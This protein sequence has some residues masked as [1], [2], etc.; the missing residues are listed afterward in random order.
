M[1]PFKTKHLNQTNNLEEHVSACSARLRLRLFE[2]KNYFFEKQKKLKS[3]QISKFD[4]SLA[5]NLE[6]FGISRLC[7]SHQKNKPLAA[8]KKPLAF[9]KK[10]LRFWAKLLF[11]SKN[12]FYETNF[13][14]RDKLSKE[15]LFLETNFFLR[16][17]FFLSQTSSFVR[18]FV[19]W[20]K[21]CFS[22]KMKFYGQCLFSRWLIFL[23]HFFWW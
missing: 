16:K 7:F 23:S 21:Y 9:L 1:K 14:S 2:L 8:L 12:S 19:F 11:S 22:S 3:A 20:D 18:N 10:K 6:I 17:N 4:F 5:E 15:K 13:V